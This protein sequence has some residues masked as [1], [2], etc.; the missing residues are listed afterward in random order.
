VLDDSGNYGERGRA[1]ALAEFSVERMVDRTLAV[2]HEA[3]RTRPGVR[4]RAVP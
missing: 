4:H 3:L 1:R 2:Y